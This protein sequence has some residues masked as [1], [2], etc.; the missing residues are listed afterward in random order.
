MG[1]R[2]NAY[3]TVWSVE[4][5]SDRFTKGRISISRKDKD[6]GTYVT[7]FSGFVNFFGTSVAGKAAKL[8][9]GDRI[10]LTGIDVTTKYEKET[11]R[12]FT[13][14]NVYDFETTENGATTRKKGKIEDFVNVEEDDDEGLP[15]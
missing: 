5:V 10:K 7:D 9:E 13:N 12:N 6:S 4:S 15:F 11:N 1:F 2:E 14:F 8:K 3:A